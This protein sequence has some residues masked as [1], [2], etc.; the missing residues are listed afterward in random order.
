MGS[1][2]VFAVFLIEFDKNDY[3]N[4]NKVKSS[5][6]KLLENNDKNNFSVSLRTETWLFFNIFSQ[7][8]KKV[9]PQKLD[10]TRGS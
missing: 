1:S 10:F 6:Y 9:D 3:V 4:V 7:E 8:N 5:I 2:I